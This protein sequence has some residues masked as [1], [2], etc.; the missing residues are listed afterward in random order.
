MIY[1][2]ATRELKNKME[3][4]AEASWKS[5]YIIAGAVTLCAVLIFTLD[6]G[7][8]MAGEDIQLGTQSAAG[9]FSVFQADLFAGLRALGFLNII[10]WSLAVPLYCALFIAHRQE[11]KTYAGFA[12]LIYLLGL[13]IYL[14]NNAAIPMA[15]LSGKYAAAMTDAQ[16]SLL[17]AAGEAI[18]V[19]GED[20]TPGAFPGMFFMQAAGM[21]M[22]II[23][24][25]ARTFPRAAAYTGVF[26]TMLLFAYTICYTFFPATHAV[27][28]I[29]A[30]L[31][32]ISGMAWYI[33]VAIQLLKW[34]RHLGYPEP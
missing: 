5:I 10:A 15:V 13:A 30:M 2:T 25:L 6:I 17:A 27:A 19:Q 8:S 21:G 23:M 26:G 7:L 33:Q 3:I 1:Q 12:S 14:S 11:Y 18:L 22:A 20:F 31:G 28:M 32:G 29:L 34:S 4:P 24:L 16:R 9:W